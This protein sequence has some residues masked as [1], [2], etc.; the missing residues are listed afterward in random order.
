MTV[1]EP[2]K[3]AVDL[4][5]LTIDGIEVSVPKGTLLIRAAEELGIAIPRFCDHPL[6]APAGACRQCLVEVA[7]PDREGNVRPMPKPQASCTMTATPGM[8]VKTQLTSAV[9]EKAQRGVMELLL[10]NHPLDCPVCDKGGEC[11]LQNQA[12]ANGQPESRFTEVKRTFPKPIR[13]STQVLLDRER[14]ILCQRCT[15][16]S[17]EI[18]GDPFI[19]LQ[20]RGA[21]QQIGT[22]SPGVL[23]FHVDLP[24]PVVRTSEELEPTVQSQTQGT[25]TDESRGTGHDHRTGTYAADSIDSARTTQGEALLDESGQPFASYFSGNTIQICPVGAL[26]GAAYRFRARPFDL[27]STKGVCEHCAGGCAL[28]V[29][30]RRG[31][32]TRRLA[33]EDPEVNEEWNC[34]KGRW[35]FNWSTGADRLTHPL[36]RDPES[37]ELE[38]VSWPYAIEVAAAGLLKAREANGVGVLPGGRLTVG[39]AY[40][41]AKFARIVLRTNDIDFRARSHS[42]EEEAFL[43]HA[44][45]GSGLGVTFAAVE[46]APAVLLAG[47][48]AEEEAASLFLRL[49]KSVLR[50]GKKV[51]SIAPWASRGLIKLSGTLIQTLPGQEAAAL[52]SPEAAAAVAEPGS[53]ILLGPRL[54]ESPGAYQAALALAAS[55]GARLAWVPRRSG[56]RGAVEAGLLPGLLPGGRPVSDPAARVDIAAAWD[57]DSL[58]ATPG[59]DAT[60]MV[61]DAAGGALSGLLVGGVD[62]DDLP[63]PAA[64]RAALENASFVVSLEV[65]ASA[66]TAYADVVLPVAPPA[67]KGGTFVNW[68]GRYREFPQA[69]TSDALSDGE[70]LDALASEAGYRLGLK[71]EQ[72]GTAELAQL[73]TWE[74]ARAAKPEAHTVAPAGTTLLSTWSMLL[75]RGRLQDG[76]PYLAGTAHRAVARV[77]PATAT[78]LGVTPGVPGQLTV[79]TDR[80]EITLPLAVTPMPDGVVW[81]PSNSPGSPVRS[82][83]AAGNGSPVSVRLASDQLMGA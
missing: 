26:T 82:R 25:A 61:D 59:R 66:V 27:V 22:F 49:R 29:D 10:I 58:P 81:L 56:E 19:D 44:V 1:T 43:G 83:L 17:K 40:A 39:D 62:P 12:L 70:V 50:K 15:R 5:T 52:G 38:P 6:L 57:V 47:L 21:H 34:D 2:S 54:T 46:G 33:A 74:G 28:R 41:Y 68:E 9:S 72:A 35:A 73:G 63:D 80:G 64:A 13:I 79:S 69:L 32:V 4:V 16:F 20:M 31:K 48:E 76:E 3:P 30:H 65:R 71:G 11:P 53:V 78:E 24:D 67:E 60:R 14:C 23:N 55:S 18:A 7:M 77:S 8:V 36:V 42:A 37:G 45:A 75:D 51:T